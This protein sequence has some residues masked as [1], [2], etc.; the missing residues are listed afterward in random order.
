MTT[1]DVGTPNKSL[2]AANGS[3]T[4]KHIAC[5]PDEMPQADYTPIRTYR[6]GD[7]FAYGKQGAFAE[8]ISIYDKRD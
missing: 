5:L 7:R 8:V 4:V 6:I 1:H 2:P 3:I